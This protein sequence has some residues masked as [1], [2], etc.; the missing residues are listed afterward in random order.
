[1]SDAEQAV[2][3]DGPASAVADGMALS[4]DSSL[5]GSEPTSEPD[6]ADLPPG[7]A[8]LDYDNP[9]GL[10]LDEFGFLVDVSNPMVAK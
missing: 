2:A 1:M 5:V 8:Q 10:E 4:V 7:S 6:E 9:E 3:S